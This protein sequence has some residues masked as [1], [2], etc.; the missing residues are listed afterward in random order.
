MESV[1]RSIFGST[2]GTQKVAQGDT[3][4]NICSVSGQVIV[5]DDAT[6]ES[7]VSISGS[8]RVG[9]NCKIGAI[10]SASGSVKINESSHIGKI[11]I[12]SGSLSIA[13]QCQVES[14]AVLSGSTKIDKNSQIKESLICSSGTLRLMPNVT[15]DGNIQTDSGNIIIEE[16]ASLG[17]DITFTEMPK[18]KLG[19][20]RANYSKPKLIIASGSR[21][22]GNIHLYRKVDVT[23]PPEISPNKIIRHY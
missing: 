4:G 20:F 9:S 17:G 18:P 10:K 3:S 8:I 11:E 7:I 16:N 14:I 21:L 23:L 15:V 1:I 19:F 12:A 13:Q 2:H 5:Q 22:E 6:V